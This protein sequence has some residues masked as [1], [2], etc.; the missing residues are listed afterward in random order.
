ML[1]DYS[2][3]DSLVVMIGLRAT[4]VHHDPYSIWFLRGS[5]AIGQWPVIKKE[6][7]SEMKCSLG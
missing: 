7:F 1:A 3:T 4:D 6:M 2:R 5:P